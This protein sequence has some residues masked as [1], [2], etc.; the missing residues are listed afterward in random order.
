MSGHPVVWQTPQPLWT[1][2]GATSAA[3]AAAADQARPAILRFASDDFMDQ[4]FATLARDPSRLDGLLAR[5]ETWR[6]PAAETAGL[7]E[8]TPIPSQAQSALR[9]TFA[10]NG[11]SAVAP[12]A[13]EATVTEQAR[14]RQRPL[15]L[16]HP[17]HQR[18]YLVGASLVC[19]VPGLPER[20]VTPGG[21]EQVSFV[22]RRLL[23]EPAGSTD[24][25]ALREFA[26]V[27]DDAGARWQRVAGG[28]DE[29]RPV[30][31]EEMLPVFPLP[32]E[33]DGERHR[34][35]WGGLVPV[36][37]REEYMGASVE[38]SPAPAFAAG[39]LQAVRGAQPAAPRA[40]KQARLAQFGMQVAEPW[41]NLIRLSHAAADSLKEA[42]PISGDSESTTAKRKRVFDHNLQQQQASWLVL[43][44]FADW[45]E[46][47]LTEVWTAV[48][49]D[50]AGSLEGHRR[51]LFDWLGTAAMP[52]GIVNGLK[53]TDAGADLQPPQ[54]SL[55]AALR[56]VRAAGVR[57]KLEATELL[58][59]SASL[60]SSDWPSFH[61]VL[62]GVTTATPAAVDGPWKALDTLAAPT[63]AD[64]T[65]PDP[66]A[67]SSAAEQDAAQVDRLTAL[68]GRALEA[69]PETDAPP[70]PFALQLRDALRSN[71]GDAGWFV[72]RFVYTRTDCGPLHPPVLSAAT[73]RFQ[74]ASFFDPD[75]PAR[76]IRI[77]LPLDTSPA[78]L[79]KF[80]RNTAF[81]ISDMLC[82][83]I[84]R[85]KGLGL[86][87]LVR[88][89]LPWPLHKDLD[90]GSGGSC[91][92]GAGISIG[93]ICSLSI[94]II[95][96]CALILL[97]I[98]V[99]LLDLVFRWLPFFIMCFPLPRFGGKKATA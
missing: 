12:T 56:A 20:A 86:V 39:Q 70:L 33:D 11:K 75:A 91:H 58:Y 19:G 90:V 6:A 3:A 97:I 96:I 55:R 8:R 53:L 47:Y 45:L 79:R 54:P 24:P 46:A 84:Q 83:Q 73:Q 7:V 49:D 38:R 85:A 17:A 99:T 65:E 34:T 44:D 4:L 76:P 81:V 28:V 93:M 61:F 21:S 14:T 22:V 42:S 60:G 23:P 89:V 51:T 62:A 29:G 95:T 98:I 69:R 94:P 71:I 63:P 72:A 52:A 88:A 27:K 92:N 13:A 32:Y 35:M 1:R 43:L 77:T 26:L 87:D 16:Y 80:N 67:S 9:R 48:E 31:G 30:A 2:F 15:K 74:L 66:L 18:F 64:E 37:R 82:G 40:S 59:T 50:A 78:G 41:K 10:R 36:G 68:V 25:A 5:P 57:E